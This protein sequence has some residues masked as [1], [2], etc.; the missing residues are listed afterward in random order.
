[1]NILEEKHVCVIACNLRE[2]VLALLHAVPEHVPH[3]QLLFQLSDLPLI[4]LDQQCWILALIHNSI[5]DNAPHL[6]Q[7]VQVEDTYSRCPVLSALGKC[8]AT[9]TARWSVGCTQPPFCRHQ[10]LYQQAHP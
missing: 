10:G 1:M 8:L 4:L 7:N 9:C 5:S 6:Q 3:S 2:R